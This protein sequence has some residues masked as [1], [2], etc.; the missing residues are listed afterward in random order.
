[1]STPAR[2]HIAQA[3]IFEDKYL[4][5]FAFPGMIPDYVR[6]KG[7]PAR[8]MSTANAITAAK[9]TLA[10][11]LMA[12]YVSGDKPERY[13][14]IDGAEFAAELHA[15]GITPTLFAEVYGTTPDRVV[16]DWIDGTR[17]IPHPARVLVGLFKTHP[18]VI[19]TAERI[20]AGMTEERRKREELV[21]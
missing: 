19:A 7:E 15:A 1:M 8:F 5:Q 4:G 21:T 3:V 10:E 12:R 2:R 20:T 16:T 13:R 11:A 17:D 18:N 6:Y 14:F 9:I